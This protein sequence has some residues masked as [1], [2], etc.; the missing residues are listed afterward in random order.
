VTCHAEQASAG[1]PLWSL[2]AARR[3]WAADG[4]RVVLTNGCFDLL[5]V[6]HVRYLAAARALGD[7]LVVAV[8]D[9][10]STRRRKGPRRPL[11]S[12]AERMELLAAL[13]MVDAVVPFGE[14]TAVGVVRALLPDVYVKGGDYD[15][16]LARPPEA[17]AAAACGAEVVFVPF[18]VGHSTSALAERIARRWS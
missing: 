16:A 6:G 11:V 17:D 13:R 5:H 12:L 1:D 8:N 7:V 4:L 9:D 18:E 14:D 10:A 15:G 2:A 3:A